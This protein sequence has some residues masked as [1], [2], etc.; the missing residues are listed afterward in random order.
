MK[1]DKEYAGIISLSLQLSYK[2]KIIPNKK[3]IQITQNIGFIKVHIN[4]GG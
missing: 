1:L 3:F 4:V 2:L